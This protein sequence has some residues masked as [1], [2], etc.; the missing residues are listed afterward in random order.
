MP[1]VC[2]PKHRR[3]MIAY[4]GTRAAGSPLSG[5]MCTTPTNGCRQ[6]RS[7]GDPLR[8]GCR[9]TRRRSRLVRQAGDR[10]LAAAAD[11]RSRRSRHPARSPGSPPPS[12]AESAVRVPRPSR[13]ADAPTPSNPR[14]GSLPARV[15]PELSDASRSHAENAHPGRDIDGLACGRAGSSPDIDAVRASLRSGF[16]AQT[17]STGRVCVA[18]ASEG[19]MH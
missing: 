3:E 1:K 14:A 12:A 2:T 13:K 8:G 5:P 7:T 16:W 11:A 6:G 10:D 17:R 15:L 18:R 9:L 4:A 19:S